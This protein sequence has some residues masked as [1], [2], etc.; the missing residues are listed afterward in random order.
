MLRE[1]RGERVWMGTESGLYLLDLNTREQTEIPIAG[2]DWPNKTEPLIWSMAE[3]PNGDLWLGT[4]FHGIYLWPSA[5]VA[6]L[7]T[8]KIETIISESSPIR[9]IYAIQINA[10]RNRSTH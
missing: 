10:G 3:S 4:I 5:S 7:D 6:S 1:T 9:T 8:S 2:K